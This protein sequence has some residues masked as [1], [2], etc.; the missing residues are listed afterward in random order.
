[1][2]A[3]LSARENLIEEIKIR[4]GDGIIDI[5]L[6]PKHY[7]FAVT[8]SLQRYR[9]RSGNALEQ[10]F[11]F[12]D[13][14]PDQAVYTLPNEIQEVIHVSRRTMGGS[15]GGV[16][17]DPFSLAFVNNIYMI[18]NPGGL[19]T[20]GAG[21]LATYD[22]AMGFQNVAGRMFGR[23]VMFY[24]DTSSK[25]LTLYRKFTST[26]QIALEVRNVKPEEIILNDPYAAIWIRDYAV[27]TAKLI[28]GESR[29]KFANIA[30]PQGGIALNGEAMKNEAKD[31]M[32]RLD[33]ELNMQVESGLGWPILIF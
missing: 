22:M 15:S 3:Q 5:E 27:A 30:G 14:Q 8:N 21:M 10:S 13:V 7:N 16:A 19:G 24:F 32:V 29:S 12:L 4:L 25:R 33:T 11:L 2:T 26:E 31:E 20:T 6:D 1:M 28:I 23:E 18:Q 9:Q 17:I